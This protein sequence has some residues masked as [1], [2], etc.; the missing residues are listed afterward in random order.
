MLFF[1]GS[2]PYLARCSKQDD[3]G[4]TFSVP[5]AAEKCDG[6]LHSDFLIHMLYN[7]LSKAKM[8]KIVLVQKDN[9]FRRTI[10][11]LHVAV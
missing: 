1:S 11:Q 5:H 3:T 2:I 7:C 10:V 6:T 8:L 4:T 9:W